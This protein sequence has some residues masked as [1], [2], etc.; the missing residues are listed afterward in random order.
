MGRFGQKNCHRDT[1]ISV[2]R[3]PRDDRLRW[4]FTHRGAAAWRHRPARRQRSI[5]QRRNPQR[6]QFHG[7][8][9]ICRPAAGAYRRR[10][11]G[12]RG[13]AWLDAGLRCLGNWCGVVW[14]PW[15]YHS[16]FR[17]Q[18][19]HRRYAH[20]PLAMA[21]AH[22][23]PAQPV[24]DHQPVSTVALDRH[25]HARIPCVAMILPHILRA[26]SS[27]A[28]SEQ[29]VSIRPAQTI[30]PPPN[31]SVCACRGDVKAMLVGRRTPQPAR[32]LTGSAARLVGYVLLLLHRRRLG[33]SM[34][35]QARPQALK[36]G[37]SH[38]AKSVL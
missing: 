1:R 15:R 29:N 21:A 27:G 18:N 11:V 34:C 25:P 32:R 7:A 4:H 33:T 17:Q 30:N 28:S 9:R 38:L 19:G 35:L 26:G 31:L 6:L 8:V 16:R 23:G 36:T 10:H 24:V 3:R 13:I 14:Q 37:N 5:L 22:D 2:R 20:Q 12:P